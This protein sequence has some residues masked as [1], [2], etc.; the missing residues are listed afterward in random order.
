MRISTFKST[1]TNNF[2]YKQYIYIAYSSKNTITETKNKKYKLSYT[3]DTFL[4]SK[5]QETKNTKAL[6]QNLVD[7]NTIKN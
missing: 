1:T 3:T 2:K 4:I 7:T 5:E 6:I